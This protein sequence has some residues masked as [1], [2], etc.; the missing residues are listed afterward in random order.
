MQPTAPIKLTSY[1]YPWELV[2]VNKR[3]AAITGRLLWKKVKWEQ[4]QGTLDQTS[5]LLHY[6]TYIG[7]ITIGKPFDIHTMTQ[8]LHDIRS[9]CKNISAFR[10]SCQV[11]SN[12]DAAQV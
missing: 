1:S 4:V 7:D 10:L 2:T 9:V 6:E 11:L 3:F 12:E 5:R 8:T